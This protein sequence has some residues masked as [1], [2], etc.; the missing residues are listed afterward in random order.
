MSATVLVKAQPKTEL[1]FV[2]LSSL[3]PVVWITP[4]LVYPRSSTE[5]PVCLVFPLVLSLHFACYKSL[6]SITQL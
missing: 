1:S 4:T 2:P 3:A 6:L 5:I